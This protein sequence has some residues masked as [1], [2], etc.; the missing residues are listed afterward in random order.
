MSI[1]LVP[2]VVK[3]FIRKGIKAPIYMALGVKRLKKYKTSLLAMINTNMRNRSI[4][5]NCYQDFCVDLSCPMT[6]A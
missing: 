3:P 1:G 4:L 2:V 5:F 6:E